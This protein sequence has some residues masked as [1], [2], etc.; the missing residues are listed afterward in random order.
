MSLSW[1]R[2]SLVVFVSAASVAGCSAI[3]NPENS[4]DVLRCGNV[5]DCYADQTVALALQDKRLEAACNAPGSDAAGD[6]ISQSN[7]SKVCSTTYKQIS[8]D[9]SQLDQLSDFV[10]RYK[11]AV[12]S[13]GIYIACQVENLGKQGCKPNAGA[14]D[15]DLEVNDL[16]ICDN[17]NSPIPAYEASTENAGQDVLDQYC[18]QFYCDDEGDNFGCSRDKA[19]KLICKRCDPDK[20]IGEGGCATMWVNGAPS[21]VYVT[22]DDCDPTESSLANSKFGPLPTAPTP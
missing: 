4:D 13:N 19:N 11:E 5:D 9:P 22:G 20:P 12:D 15:A 10:V 21:S 18:R 3:F 1:L 17:P 6:D 8:C 14:C 7:E 2:A 16:G